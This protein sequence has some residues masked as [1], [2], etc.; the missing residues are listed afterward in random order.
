MFYHDKRKLWRKKTL[1]RW[2][3]KYSP[4]VTTPRSSGGSFS[5]TLDGVFGADTSVIRNCTWSESSTSSLFVWINLKASKLGLMV[6]V[7]LLTLF[8][9]LL[10]QI[11]LILFCPFKCKELSK[12]LALH[13][14]LDEQFALQHWWRRWW[15]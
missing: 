8:T 15:T 14:T 11:M 9:S 6:V 1:L 7:V 13:F 10:S 12:S 5:C 2:K 3:K 4:S